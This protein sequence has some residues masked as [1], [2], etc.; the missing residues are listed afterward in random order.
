MRC[1]LVSSPSCCPSRPP[2]FVAGRGGNLGTQKGEGDQGRRGVEGWASLEL[3]AFLEI[4]FL[5]CGREEVVGRVASCATDLRRDSAIYDTT[6]GSQGCLFRNGTLLS[7]IMALGLYPCIHQILDKMNKGHPR[8][9][10]GGGLG[11][12]RCARDNARDNARVLLPFLPSSS[13][14]TCI[15]VSCPH[16]TPVL[17]LCRFRV[18]PSLPS[19]SSS[20]EWFLCDES[21]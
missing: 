17:T 12:F 19:S 4:P 7:D 8:G 6:F 5:A 9:E 10:K 18:P 2:R 15:L 3:V 1:R 21:R 11:A 20:V 16:Q 13:S 14:T